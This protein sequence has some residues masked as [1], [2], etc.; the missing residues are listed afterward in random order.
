MLL[1]AR[2]REATREVTRPLLMHADDRILEEKQ[3]IIGR[4]DDAV[5]DLPSPP[6]SEGP[7]PA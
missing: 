1:L 3:P 7:S 5:I 2:G 6:L 4:R